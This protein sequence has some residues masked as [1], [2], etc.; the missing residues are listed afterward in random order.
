MRIVTDHADYVVTTMKDFPR[1][2]NHCN[3]AVVV[4]LTINCLIV[5]MMSIFL[6]SI[7]NLAIFSFS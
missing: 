5:N 3:L 4:K 1:K 2:L 7:E 6:H